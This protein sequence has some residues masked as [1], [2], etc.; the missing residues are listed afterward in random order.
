MTVDLE[1]ELGLLTQHLDRLPPEEFVNDG[2]EIER[3]N[4]ENQKRLFLLL[5]RQS[6]FEEMKTAFENHQVESQTNSPK[7]KPPESRKEIRAAKVQSFIDQ[8]AQR[9]A[10]RQQQNESQERALDSLMKNNQKVQQE[11]EGDLLARSHHIQT[12]R[13]QLSEIGGIKM[14]IREEASAIDKTTSLLIE[15]SRQLAQFYRWS[16]VFHTSV[17]SAAL[18]TQ[19]PNQ[20]QRYIG[21]ML[22][23]I[24][25]EIVSFHIVYVWEDIDF[26]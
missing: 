10:E 13:L 8:M 22:P 2:L 5:K 25:H 20:I 14:K 24:T 3:L 18:C 6:Q 15:S 11:M 17:A 4:L 1:A 23:I 21:N 7:K 19:A 9:L 12:L 26:L 16:R